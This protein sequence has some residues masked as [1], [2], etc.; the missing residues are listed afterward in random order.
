MPVSLPYLAS[1]KNLPTLFERIASAKIP[2]RFNREFLQTTIGLKGSN[3]RALIPFLRNCG[4]LDQSSAPSPT[5]RLLKGDKRRAA[6]ADGVRKAYGPLFDADHDA[7][8]ATGEKL[9]GLVAQIAGTDDDLT[10]RISNT[11][12]SLTK[13]GDFQTDLSDSADDEEPGEPANKSSSANVNNDNTVSNTARLRPEFHY[14]IQI[15]L[16]SN[17]SEE[18]YINIFNAIRK[19]FQ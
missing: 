2:D 9:K 6:I 15:Y 7:H 4:F 10:S 3:D 16:P 1:N 8:K 17:G 11:F 14:N 18:T 19:T 5:Y 12:S 13:L